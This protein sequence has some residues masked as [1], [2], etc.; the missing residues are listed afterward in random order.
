MINPLLLLGL[1]G[2]GYYFYTRP[3]A[4]AG[5]ATGESLGWSVVDAKT[6]YS[7]ATL[8]VLATNSAKP[9]GVVVKFEAKRGADTAALT[10][11]VVDIRKIGDERVWKVVTVVADEKLEDL[12]R[13]SAT[14]PAGTVFFLKDNQIG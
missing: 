1:L 14:V 12:K 4:S 10:G 13:D 5:S 6:P 8:D 11:R 2:V 7:T 3:A 9:S